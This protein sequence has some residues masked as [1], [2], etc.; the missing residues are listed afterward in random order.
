V[1]GF[2]PIPIKE[3]FDRVTR[4]FGY[5]PA[6]VA[7]SPAERERVADLVNDALAVAWR[8][9]FWPFLME[10]RRIAY[11]PAWSASDAY[12]E[13][14]EVWHGGR[15]WRASSD[16]ASGGN[17]PE[18]N[19]CWQADPP[20]FLPSF[21]FAANAI[22][23]CDL[24]ACVY[25][26]HPDRS[27]DARPFPCRRTDYGAVVLGPD[28]PALPWIRYRPIPPRYTWANTTASETPGAV[29]FDATD[30]NDY[31]RLPSGEAVALPFPAPFLGF[32]VRHAAAVRLRDEDGRAEALGEAWAEL[33]R[34]QDAA[35]ESIRAPRRAAVRLFRRPRP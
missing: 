23:E 24:A 17:P 20:D 32:V 14:D 26:T 16:I 11:R 12:A 8:R 28:F 31:A 35:E 22:D 27:A 1:A 34:A 6:T 2:A 29:W 18:T 3:V 10:V 15:Y 30:G 7:Y 5:D 4:G 9:S 21:P 19:D 33:D 25:A 13:G